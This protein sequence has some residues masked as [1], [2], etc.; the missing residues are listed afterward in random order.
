MIAKVTRG[1]GFKGLQSYLLA[2]KGGHEADRVSWISSRNLPSPDPELAAVFM[3]DTA[4]KSKRVEKPVYHLTI[5]LAPEE[6]LDREAML[7]VVDQTLR[8]VGLDEHQALVVAHSDTRHRHVHVMLNRVHPVRHAAW[9]NGHDY[10]RMERSLRRQE[11]ELGLRLVPGRHYSTPGSE[12]H[13]GA[14]LSSGDRRFAQR[15]GDR[16]FGD[17]VREVA[18]ADLKEA[19]S[20]GEL[21]GRLAEYGLHLE[22]R[23]RG[24]A[25]TDGRQRVKASYVDRES[26]LARLEARLGKWEPAGRDLPAGKSERWRDIRDLRQAAERLWKR[27][28]LDQ[29]QRAERLDRWERNR[30]VQERPRLEGRAH[31]AS[32]DLDQ[33]LRSA[34][35]N[36]TEA[37][38]AVERHARRHGVEAT[39]RELAR[40][41]GSFGQLHGRGGPIPSSVRQTA[42]GSARAAG[43]ALRDL[44]RARQGLARLPKLS[45]KVPLP[46]PATRQRRDRDRSSKGDLART[47]KRLVKNV[48]WS[49]AARVMPVVHYQVLKLTLSIPRRVMEASL[50]R[51]RGFRR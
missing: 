1:S 41:P 50:G 48:G 12:R 45:R 17:H 47:A 7:K 11:Q 23:G 32:R 42:T 25:F 51:E 20:W 27:H 8:D 5:S 18:R 46:A 16:P 36:P 21:H 15:T 26:S 10:A 33:R 28:E 22:K 6:R 31:A 14:E 2:G 44:E 38:Q 43:S 3:R 9:D 24:L 29:Q 39:A 35:R 4:A 30:A 19:R 40:R 13:Q 49:L 34:Y 37:R